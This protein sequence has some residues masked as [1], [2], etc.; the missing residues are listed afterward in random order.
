MRKTSPPKGTA[1]AAAPE[2]SRPRRRRPPRCRTAAPARAA[3]PRLRRRAPAQRATQSSAVASTQERSASPQATTLSCAAHPKKPCHVSAGVVM[4]RTSPGV[5]HSRPGTE[6]RSSACNAS[7]SGSTPLPEVV[8]A[9]AA[10]SASATA[11][12]PPLRCS[13][14]ASESEHFGSSC[15]AKSFASPCCAF[16]S[17]SSRA[18]ADAS[19]APMALA[20]AGRARAAVAVALQRRVLVR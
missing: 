17:A 12:M 13:T 18:T 15:S 16:A 2:A 4:S 9:G 5:A 8:P 3:G 10:A 20:R 14:R 19:A 6:E 1:A 7:V 11:V